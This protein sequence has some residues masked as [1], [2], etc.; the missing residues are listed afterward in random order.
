MIRHIKYILL[1]VF[2]IT[3]RQNLFCQIQ[4]YGPH[5][6]HNMTDSLVW[7]YNS[8]IKAESYILSDIN[9]LDKT[10]ALATQNRSASDWPDTGLDYYENEFEKS[11]EFLK[12]ITITN[13]TFILKN[14]NFI[15]NMLEN[16]ITLTDSCY[17]MKKA[18]HRIHAGIKH[19]AENDCEGF[20]YAVGV[21]IICVKHENDN[22]GHIKSDQKLNQ[23]KETLGYMM[24]NIGDMKVLIAKMI[25]YCNKN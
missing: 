22:T 21:R 6:H 7:V 5:P 25:G 19:L 4:L 13:D 11:R 1:I 3:C 17:Q 15:I 18:M 9:K 10:L 24:K 23:W 14:S 8:L 20:Y 2:T 12:K 16:S